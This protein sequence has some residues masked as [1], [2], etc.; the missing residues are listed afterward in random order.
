MILQASLSMDEAARQSQ[1]SSHSLGSASSSS[2]SYSSTMRRPAPSHRHHRR[3]GSVGTVSEHEARSIVHSSRSSINSASASSMDSLD[4][5][6][7]PEGQDEPQ[8][9]SAT[10][11][12]Q[13]TNQGQASSE[14]HSHL[15]PGD[16]ATVFSPL[17]R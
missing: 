2:S 16:S 12:P 14:V 17:Y 13:G 6:L 3:T 11:P 5:V 10:P 15:P 7:R 4:S 9:T 8:Q 1:S